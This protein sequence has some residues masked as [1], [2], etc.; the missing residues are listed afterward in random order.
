MGEMFYFLS[1]FLPLF[2]YPL[3][4]ACLLLGLALWIGRRS[5]WQTR[6]VALALALLWLGGN[7]MVAMPLSRSL[8]WRYLPDSTLSSSGLQADVIVVLGGGTRAHAFPRPSTELNEAGDRLLYAAQLYQQGVASR[9]LV[10]GGKPA[11]LGPATVSGAESMADIFRIIGIPRE[12]LWLE[13]A[14]RNTYENAVGTEAILKKEGVESVILVTSAMHMPRAYGLFAKT[15]LEVIPA[16]TD[17]Q[18]TQEDWAYYTQP[19][20]VLQLFN[21]LPSADNLALTTRALKE[22]VGMGVYRLRGWL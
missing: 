12:A 18:V 6:I 19:D 20:L 9:I 21:L 22:Y 1:K 11:L 10:A 14:S 13:A 4:L 3:G 8:E 15:D 5:Y 17:F 7:R 16:P 2:I